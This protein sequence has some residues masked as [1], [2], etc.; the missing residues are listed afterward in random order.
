[1]PV[2][3]PRPP[4]TRDRALLFA[5]AALAGTVFTLLHEV[6]HWV[7]ARAVGAAPSFHWDNV[8]W[9]GPLGR[10]AEVAA[11]AGGPLVTWVLAGTGAAIVLRGAPA[12]HPLGTLLAG[13]ALRFPLNVLALAFGAR[14][15]VG[16]DET[17]L[18]RL[19]HLPVALVQVVTLAAALALLA[20]VFRRATWC[21][22]DAAVAAGIGVAGTVV[23]I[24]VL[25]PKALS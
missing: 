23:W 25:G 17:N 14:S 18:A 21:G 11:T 1:M 4:T 5:G 10:G 8:D 2:A 15:T 12:P 22:R 20:F 9:D 13:A 24:Y 3:V 6:G 16:N 19:W 7:A